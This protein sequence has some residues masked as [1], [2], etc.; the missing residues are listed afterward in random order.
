MI[1][2]IDFDNIY[3]LYIE[4][5][6]NII[7]IS[8]LNHNSKVSIINCNN[9]K[10][11]SKSFQYSLSVTIHITKGK[12]KDININW[13]QLDRIQFLSI[14]SRKSVNI[15]SFLPHSLRC[16]VIEGLKDFKLLPP[17]HLRE[18]TI[19]SCP[20]FN[21]FRNFQH[22]S[23]VILKDLP[24]KTLEGFNGR[25][26]FVH[27]ARCHELT[28]FSPLNACEKVIIEDCK[29]FNSSSYSYSRITDAK[30]LVL[31][32]YDTN[33]RRIQQLQELKNVHLL[34][35]GGSL[36]YHPRIEDFHSCQIVY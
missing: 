22:I 8:C 32:H 29:W 24:I 17:N 23:K 14:Q 16:F 34:V 3:E 4:D 13:N 36:S 6:Q 26:G 20:K 2:T 9:I 27:I 28:V 11:Y 15:P 12:E 21:S 5:C 33:D 25:K 30:Q 7:D 1:N 18:I 35:P 10:D 19:S 31:I